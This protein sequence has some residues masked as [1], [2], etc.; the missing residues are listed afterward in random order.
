MLSGGMSRQNKMTDPKLYKTW[1]VVR[2]L[3]EHARNAL[4][5]P[6]PD[7]KAE[8]DRLLREHHDILDHNELELAL[9]MLEELGNLVPCRGGFWKDLE[10]AAD[11]MKLHHRAA[12]FREQFSAA[13]DRSNERSEQE[14]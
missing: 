4:P 8:F 6:G 12:H 11:I 3:F 13:L 9:D 2:A 14:N 5:Q 7:Q 1:R 10:R